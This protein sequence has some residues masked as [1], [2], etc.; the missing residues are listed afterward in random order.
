M[1][2]PVPPPEPPPVVHL[3]TTPETDPAPFVVEASSA[4]VAQAIAP[5]V[6][7]TRPSAPEEFT[8]ELSPLPGNVTQNAA[9]LGPSAS[10]DVPLAPE[11]A[12]ESGLGAENA[13]PVE[14]AETTSVS[15]EPPVLP[16][17][18]EA[19]DP[20]SNP[21]SLTSP[22]TSPL[23]PA[24][25]D[26]PPLAEPL[27]PS[28]S[29][30]EPSAPESP[31]PATPAP[32]VPPM[33]RRSP[34]PPPQPTTTPD[35]AAPV[36][37]GSVT[38]P[39]RDAPS[40]DAETEGDRPLLEIDS[41]QPPTPPES[42]RP[43]PPAP[44]RPAPAPATPPATTQ[45]AAAPGPNPLDLIEL[46]ADRQEYDSVRQV[47]TAEGNVV[48]RFRG[49][50]LDA[51]RL[52]VSIPNR[53]AVA[54]GDVA[55]T[56]GAQVLRGN[57]FEYDFV[58]G[59][60]TIQ[61]ASGDIFVPA[62]GSDF[63][64][65]DTAALE[66]GVLP[67]RPLSDRVRAS[68][69]L[70]RVSNPGGISVTV[71]GG[72]ASNLPGS[73]TGGE[74][75]RLR[76]EADN[77]EFTPDGWEAEDV[78]ITNDPFSPPELEVRAERA[79]LTR[80][81]PYQDELR[82]ERPRV[83]FDQGFSLPL[84]RDRLVFD[85][86]EREP[87]LVQFGFDAEDRGG[88]YVERSFEPISTPRVRLVI[89]PQF[90][91]QKVIAPDFLVSNDDNEKTGVFDPDAYGLRASLDAT[92]GPQTTLRGT[93][94]FT[95]LDL[96]KAEDNLRASLR[97]RQQLGTHSLAAEYSYRDRLFNGS[98]GFQ[99]VQSSLGL[100]L[101]SPNFRLGD[102]GI[103]ANY[104]LGAQYIRANT[105]RLD[106]LDPV[107]ENNR[108]NLG[109][110]QG[111]VGL[112]R[113]FNLWRGRALPATPEEGLRY[114][115]R[116][117]VPYVN[118][119]TSLRSTFNLYTSGDTQESVTAG[120]SLLGQF[121][122]FSKNFLDYTAFNVGYSQGL[123][124]SQS[125]FLFDRDVDREV[126]TAGITQQIYGPFRAG[127]QTSYSFTRDRT[128]STDYFLEYSRRTYGIILRYNP[129]LEF[130]SLNLRI[131]DFN[132]NGNAGPFSEVES[133]EDGVIRPNN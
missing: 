77:V 81:S 15:A 38:V 16:A 52:Q 5:E 101:T 53:N 70:S 20:P 30:E 74:V 11:A 109:R 24:E 50:V 46:V 119:N 54:T 68:Q 95:S 124:G 127:F 64:I 92:L 129:V 35:A 131:S 27:E 113:G 73:A 115:P 99:T 125:P 12:T 18:E 43:S 2:Y 87:G 114:S 25:E 106:L 7:L 82:A 56:R 97:L 84:L 14:I 100:V 79:K 86:R 59:D 29:Q 96:N 33:P 107:R 71:G 32:R 117:L 55:L 122:H 28:S 118:L 41:D 17:A 8:P 21:G 90:F 48:M 72:G 103:I 85:R 23:E 4:I 9:D 102:T 128:I 66:N 94:S 120:V 40:D 69:P 63:D 6:T 3:A 37:P 1:P 88:L 78:R 31:P 116:P 42:D 76:F 126:L 104:Q 132:W 61:G 62:V 45:P 83:V 133:V 13:E 26:L 19:V 36:P 60:G 111:T 93:T 130:G 65:N 89:T 22:S 75:R 91:L 80:L 47:V 112:F 51:D 108:V 58:Q 39:T 110:F 121:G 57:R 44:P 34:L 10:I 105:D 67:S 123:Q 98:L 49:A